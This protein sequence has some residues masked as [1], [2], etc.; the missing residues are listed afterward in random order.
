MEGHDRELQYAHGQENNP[1]NHQPFPQRE[2]WVQLIL[3][4]EN[5]SQVFGTPAV[6]I[7]DFIK[8][9][10]NLNP[11]AFFDVFVKA[12]EP[13]QDL[14]NYCRRAQLKPF[15]AKLNTNNQELIHQQ[16]FESLR[17][18]YGGQ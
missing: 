7:L 18:F 14:L 12:P 10:A 16:D 15:W 1:Q 9:K 8:E 3:D 6:D 5:L 4:F 13:H 11:E 2:A 17:A